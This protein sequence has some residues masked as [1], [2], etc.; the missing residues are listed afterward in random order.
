MES[1]EIKKQK[2]DDR[3]RKVTYA[4]TAKFAWSYWS[5]HKGVLAVSVATVM[6]YT[7][8]DVFIPKYA[9][10]L[11]DALAGA[12]QDTREQALEA[13]MT[14]L[15]VFLC[16]ALV[17]HTLRLASLYLWLHLQV[18]ILR[19]IMDDA[20]ARVQKFSADW[21]A[22]T[23]AGATV[24]RITRGMWSFD[25]MA[26]TLYM[27]LLPAAMVIIGVT[28]LQAYHWPL[29]GAMIAIGTTIYVAVSVLMSVKIGAPALDE[30]NEADSKMGGAL[31]DA[32]TCNAVVKSFGSEEREEKRFAG[33]T[34]EW[35]KK[36]RKAWG[37]M[38]HIDT[39]QSVALLGLLAAIL[40][41]ALWLWSQ[42]QATPGEVTFALVSYFVLSGYTRNVGM[43]VRDIQ[44]AKSEME[45]IIDYMRRPLD[46]ANKPDAPD[47]R[48]S[49]GEIVF[50]QVTFAYENTGKPV[51]ED[52]SVAI[53]P[54]EKVG[55]VGHSGSGKSTFVKLLQR[56][57][58]IDGGEIRIDGQNIAD[59]TQE[60]LRAQISLVAQEP[61]LFHRSLAENIAYGRPDATMDEIVRAAK[62]AHAD[63]FI[64]RLPDGYD[65][66][67]GER[68]IK[69]SGGERQRVAIARAILADAH[70]LILDEATSSLDSVS[71]ALIQDAIETLMEGRTSLVVAH[72][73]STIQQADRILV[74]DDGRIVEQGT[75]EELVKIENGRYRELFEMQAFGLVGEP[76]ESAPK[77]APENTA[78]QAAE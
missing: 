32:I 26:D 67:V 5:R 25:H 52:F 37:L 72:R 40:G 66:M 38:T 59:V 10:Q 16:L 48:V 12:T 68:G 43:F 30:S 75:H 41:T 8:A 35:L 54:G 3:C 56:L 69:L 6:A 28:A 4:D 65:T 24:R 27:G 13:A 44:K 18:P 49:D 74:F 64:A 61:I 51:Y 58:D 20:T 15:V 71:E 62:M 73:L 46:I 76:E 7:I 50:D 17:Y 77:R 60:S 31:A 19:K 57:Y 70:I 11:V 22:N 33:I 63:E 14:A 53:K 78:A 47:L 1:T 23:F 45:D 36:A 29:M 34:G 21:H 2:Y 55:L 9:G 42:G 39:V